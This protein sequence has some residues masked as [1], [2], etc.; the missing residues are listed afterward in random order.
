MKNMN[1]ILCIALISLLNLS[2]NN[3]LDNSLYDD[4]IPFG[5]EEITYDYPKGDNDIRIL[6]FNVKHCSGNDDIINYDNVSNIIK[7]LNPDFV[8][9]QELDK[10]NDRSNKD[11]QLK[12]LSQKTEMNYYF[13]KSMDY[14]GGEYGNGLLFKDSPINTK[15]LS[16]PGKEPRSAAIAEFKDLVIISTH[17]A[18]EE[19]NRIE[20]ISILNQEAKKYNKPTYLAGDFNEDK[21]DGSFFKE[22]LKD[23]EIISSEDYTFP[24]GKPTKRIDFIMKLKNY[25]VNITKSEVIYN[26]NNINMAN[27]SDHYPVYCDLSKKTVEDKYDKSE[28]DVRIANY[29]LKNCQGTDGIINYERIANII[30]AIKS[31][32]I[33]LQ[34]LDN[35]TE[36]SEGID[37]LSRL[38]ELTSMNAYFAPAIEY[39]GGTFGNG[40]LTIEKPIKNEALKLAG[41]KETRSAMIAEFDKFV[42]ASISFDTDENY[43]IQEIDEI[44]NKL[45]EYNKPAFLVGYFNEGNLES[46][47]FKKVKE[48]W[49]IISGFEPNENSS[50]NRCLDFIISLKTHEVIC[51]KNYVINDI[52][53]VD[54]ASTHF[55]I[56]CDFSNLKQ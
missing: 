4:M 33:C 8:C 19:D 23:W 40:I 48:E 1:T 44:K 9:L 52:Q 3:I 36:R 21:L 38:G 30:K 31:D 53:N 26:M 17:L 50:K 37:Q 51:N 49:N 56:F 11:D 13:S 15:T 45:S 32:V 29:F 27:A 46:D 14:K 16:L 22:L 41:K 39:K 6:S 2:C 35:E 42:I 24:T 47:F 12:I 28:N 54:L 43:R 55:P 25:N 10:N 18:L 20:S 5:K 34:G 7:N